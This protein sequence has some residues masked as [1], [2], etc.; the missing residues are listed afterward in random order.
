MLIL[1]AHGSPDPRWRAS[2]EELT[3][4]ARSES[5]RGDVRLAYLTGSPTL[6]DVVS[7]AVRAGV[8]SI[9]VLPL[10]LA[11]A[12]HVDRDIRPLVAKLR[13]THQPAELELLPPLGEHP[14]FREILQ[15]IAAE[16]PE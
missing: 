3:E 7:E 10:F 14:L 8:K 13:A 9:R 4:S 12:G 16:Q 15:R 1:I 2:L 6:A 11:S 5:G